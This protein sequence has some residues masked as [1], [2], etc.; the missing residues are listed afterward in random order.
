MSTK[1]RCALYSQNGT[2]VRHFADHTAVDI[3]AHIVVHIVAHI[4]EYIDNYSAAGYVVVYIVAYSAGH[5]GLYFVGY[6]QNDLFDHKLAGF[7][8]SP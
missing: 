4:V 3:A 6:I 7:Q 8:G 5:I 2:A 1:D